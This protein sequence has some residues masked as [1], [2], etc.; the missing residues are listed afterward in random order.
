MRN[1]LEA[2]WNSTYKEDRLKAE[3]AEL[4]RKNSMLEARNR[5][6]N[7]TLRT[8]ECSAKSLR[9]ET[10]RVKAL[11]HQVRTQ[12]ANDI[13][14]RDLQIQKMRERLSDNRR[15][16]KPPMSQIT[17]T[18][19]GATGTGAGTGLGNSLSSSRAPSAIDEDLIES[20]S[21]AQDTTDFL[22]TLS[23]SLAD[24]NDNLIALIRQCLSTLKAVQ[25]LPDEDH[26]GNEEDSDDAINP[27]TAPPI[28]YEALS[29]ELESVMYSLKDLMSQ[30]N[31]VPVEELAERDAE[32]ARLHQKNEALE[33]EWRKAIDL[34]DGWN[35]TLGRSVGGKGISVAIT[36]EVSQPLSGVMN[37]KQNRGIPE[38]DLNDEKGNKMVKVDVDIKNVNVDNVTSDVVMEGGGLERSQ[39]VEI[40]VEDDENKDTIMIPVRCQTPTKLLHESPLRNI[41]P[42]IQKTRRASRKFSNIPA[43]E[44]IDSIGVA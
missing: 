38:V 32:I 27:V 43:Q 23:Q 20:G 2:D 19:G 42:T 7:S 40:G 3:N 1:L 31:Y 37:G 44:F 9:D 11:L 25:G 10:N 6:F 18:G 4:E 28:S 41:T 35:K 36:A 33:E 14:R 5:G 8:A 21:L 13:R 16:T 12:Y 34:V 26:F 30:P 29:L 17:I 15:G 22:T 24:E 39:L